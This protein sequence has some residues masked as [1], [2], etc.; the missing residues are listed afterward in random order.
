MPAERSST[1]RSLL[2]SIPGRFEIGTMCTE[3]R[4]PG[5]DIVEVEEG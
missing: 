2:Y 5:E 1:W 4:G 3:I